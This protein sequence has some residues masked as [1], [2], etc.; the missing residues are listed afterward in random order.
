ME[1]QDEANKSH[2]LPLIQTSFLAPIREDRSL[3]NGELHHHLRWELFDERL[4]TMFEAW[5]MPPG[6]YSGCWRDKDTNERVNDESVKFCIAIRKEDL[7]K[8]RMF[9]KDFVG[10]LFRQKVIYFEHEGK[11]EFIE[12]NQEMIQ[13]LP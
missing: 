5:T 10:P 3:G 9:I 12:S 11:V 6:L 8:M 13:Q 7:D 1:K 2:S 4:Y